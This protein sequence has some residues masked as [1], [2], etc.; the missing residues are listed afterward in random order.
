MELTICYPM[1]YVQKNSWPTAQII[2]GGSRIL[3]GQTEAQKETVPVLEMVK[4]MLHWN[5]KPCF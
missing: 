5:L 2:R 4:N 1:L 3:G